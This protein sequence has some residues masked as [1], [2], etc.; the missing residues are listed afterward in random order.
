MQ[1]SNEL[2][3]VVQPKH[4]AAEAFR[5]LRTNLEF[6]R[7]SAGDVRT[8]LVTSG[9]EKEGKSTTSAN[10]A[11]AEARAGRR[12]ALVD[13]DLRRP[14]IDRFFRLSAV[15]GI[16][17]VALGRIELERAM[18]RIDL[19]L[20]GPDPGAVVPS[21]LTG[22]DAPVAEAGVL[23]VLVS[24]PLPPDP[25]EFCASYRLAEIIAQLRT[26]YDTVI[27]DTP[28]LLWVGDALTL[29]SQADAL[30]LIARLKSLRRPMVR[31]LGRI[32]DLVP[33][34]KLGFV[35]TGPI[36]KAQGVYSY[37]D[38]YSYGYGYGYGSSGGGRVE[39]PV[40][41]EKLGSVNMARRSTS[42]TQGKRPGEGDR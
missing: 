24:G 28:P 3:M 12:A 8:I 19:H 18:Q 35:V 22:S 9:I 29:S 11:V 27:I 15:E 38:G 30:I 13:L 17:D 4:N 39:S 16:T 23:D 21:L 25:G 7:F 6:V 31:E 5:L 41:G 42:T 34:R 14:Y 26:L 2:A 32:L 33:A 20:G 1:K 10:L 40:T 37:K 36:T